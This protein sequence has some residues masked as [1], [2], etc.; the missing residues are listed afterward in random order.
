[1]AILAAAIIDEGTIDGTSAEIYLANKNLV[2]DVRDIALSL[3]HACSK[4][5]KYRG[6]HLGFVSN[7]GDESINPSP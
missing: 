6:R 3:G 4:I 5:R 2:S 1:M 7:P